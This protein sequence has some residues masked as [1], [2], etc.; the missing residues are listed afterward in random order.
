MTRGTSQLTCGMFV[1]GL[2]AAQGVVPAAHA[3]RIQVRARTVLTAQL[4]AEQAV[5]VVAGELRDQRGQPVP[6]A[7]LV[8]ALATERGGRLGQPVRTDALGRYSARFSR[9][10]I[11]E[12][13]LY[14]ANASFM[15]GP[16]HGEA[17]AEVTVDLARDQ[18]RLAVVQPQRWWSVLADAWTATVVATVSG[19]PLPNVP[20]LLA[21]DGQP[22]LHLRT[23]AQGVAR[24]A[25]PIHALRRAGPHRATAIL[26]PSATRN[27]AEANWTFELLAAV[28]V[29]L[30][31][32]P[33]D[34]G[35][36]C[37]GGDWCLDGQVTLHE[38]TATAGLSDAVVQLFAERREV[39]TL[40]SGPGGRF[41]AVLH[42]DALTAF[43]HM[44]EVQLVARATANR[45]WTE[46][47]FSPIVRVAAARPAGWIEW[48]SRA[49]LA[50]AV[51]WVAWRFWQSRRR[52]RSAQLQQTAEQAGLATT[53]MIEGRERG[54][55]CFVLRAKVVHGE[56]GRPLPCRG[57]LTS[58]GGGLAILAGDDGQLLA[59]ALAPGRYQLSVTAEEHEAL[60]L[61]FD[62][63]HWGRLDGCTLLPHSCRAVVRGT[64]ARA[65]HGHTGTP[66]DWSRETPR[67]VEPRWVA[68][69]RRGRVEIREAVRTVERAL[70]GRGTG[71]EQVGEVRRAVAKVEEA[72]R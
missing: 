10:E 41:A 33:S 37:G 25:L 56:L 9:V 28:T 7:S 44:L 58:P 6:E 67:K 43:G 15:G 60:H 3:I 1:L 12:A 51:A 24:A 32:S 69:L 71:S 70:Y 14:H 42:A 16:L 57:V 36:V 38:A 35:G 31:A 11:G 27:A 2:A 34:G 13:E 72:N 66:M 21:L 47:G 22:V 8:V 62:M 19:L 26:E 18:P 68:H 50:V 52:A 46:P 40:V 20:I 39:G 49:A 54:V 4:S 29:T 65:L 30:S 23:D 5:L 48:L 53:T 55:P 45:P 61:S 64:F 63:P 59:E 17:T